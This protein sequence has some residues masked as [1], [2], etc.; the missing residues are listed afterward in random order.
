M[1]AAEPAMPVEDRAAD[2]WEP[3]VAVADHA[4]G[5]WP[6]RTRAAVL[7][8]TAEADESGQPSPWGV[9]RPVP[10]CSGAAT[11]SPPTPVGGRPV[12]WRAL[13]TAGA[14][15]RPVPEVETKT[16]RADDL[17]PLGVFPV[18]EGHLEP[19]AYLLD[20]GE[21][22]VDLDESGA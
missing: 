3:L 17:H 8:L 2:T 14:V 6:E 12:R 20:Q 4:G 19:F 16:P 13:V 10:A 5:H 15:S 9:N 1:E 11:G 7:A 21:R 18:S 22:W